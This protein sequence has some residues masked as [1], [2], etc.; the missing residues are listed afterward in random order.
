MNRISLTAVAGTFARLKLSLLRNGARQSTGRSAAFIGSV[1]LAVLL[2]ALGALGV[3][4]L[5]GN[6]HAAAG[7]T[8]LV[9]VI[10]LGWAFLP[11]FVGAADE[12][13]DPGRLAM[14]PLSPVA[15]MTGQLT[16]S[17]VG[18]GPLFTLLLLVGSAVATAHGVGGTVVA[19]V[20]VPLTLLVCTALSRTIATVNARLLTSRKGRDLAVLSG[21]VVVL[22]AQ[23]LNVVLSRLGESES[24][25]PLH[26]TA[27]VVRWIPP[28]TAVE[29]V[30]AAGDGS[31]GVALGALAATAAAAL[32][33]LEWWRRALTR[34]MVR[35]DAST[36]QDAS[37]GR[38]RRGTGETGVAARLSAS[39]T[40]TVALR[41][42]RYAW[43]N[44]KSKMSWTMALGMGLIMP[45]VSAAQGSPSIHTAYWS[46]ALLGLQMFNQFGLD[47]SGFWLV[48]QTISTPADALR[49]LRGRTGAIAVIAVPYT[50]L[51]VVFT[52][53]LSGD[54][55]A[56]PGVLGISF[57]VLGAL[58]AVGVVGSVLFPYS[59]PEDGAMKNVVP[60]QA[61]LAW[62]SILFGAVA[63][64]VLCAPVIGSAVWL[65]T[66]DSAAIGVV[67]PF[68]IVWGLFLTWAGL[69]LAA[70]RTVTRLPEIL[71][72]V[73]KA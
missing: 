3:S 73:T 13:L 64:A 21:I 70:P 55:A 10:A 29:A 46:S 61:G 20:A 39:V 16:A 1:V 7:C 48:A 38:A 33:L 14:L 28:A 53:A 45:V 40:G 72:A 43:R 6:E 23:F 54:W 47:H 50:V 41:T 57:A 11:M 12:T 15:M 58:V 22:G 51:A 52:A 30:R 34:L 8:V 27:D 17:V 63:A 42:L 25:G 44:P 66:S 24:A 32:L 19:V 37:A 67:L 62:G 2:G 9:A 36:Y 49:E 68:G 5:R 56:L 60:G 26:S 18:P 59:I 71:A 65:G 69:R 35:P 31:W 4:A